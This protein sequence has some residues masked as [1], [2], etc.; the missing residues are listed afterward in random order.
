ME[1]QIL[2]KK[3]DSVNSRL[4]VWIQLVVALKRLS[5]SGNG[6]CVGRVAHSTGI[7]NGTVSLFTSRILKAILDLKDDVVKWPNELERKEISRRNKIKYGFKHCVGVVDGTPVVFSQ[8]PA[9][10]PSSFWSRKSH[11]AINL[12]LICDDNKRIR[13]YI[14]GWPGS[15]YDSTVLSRSL[16][17]IH[18]EFFFSNKEYIL[19]D[20]DNY[21]DGVNDELA[22]GQANETGQ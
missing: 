5:V 16:V 9:V 17:A 1:M 12:Q 7:G 19:A 3:L 4:P 15:V 11:Y 13:F 2:D 22:L 10:D 21:E 14:T 6:Q 8:K 20:A 18:P